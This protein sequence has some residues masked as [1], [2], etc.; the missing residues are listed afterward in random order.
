MVAFPYRV[1]ERK[2]EG[3][4]FRRQREALVALLAAEGIKN[5]Q[6]LAAIGTVPRHLFV[7]PSLRDRAYSNV[8][9]PIGYRQT[10]SQPYIVARMLE[11]LLEPTPPR[12]VLEVGVGSGYQTALLAHLVPEVY[13]VE[14]IRP[15]LERAKANLRPFRFSHVRLKWGD[16]AEG[17]PEAA[18]FDAVIAAAAGEEPPPAWF[19][20]LTTEGRIVAPVGPSDAQ[21]LTVWRRERGGWVAHPVEPVRF[22]PLLPG[23]E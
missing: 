23:K 21:W 20:Q 13:G 7:D 17:L 4:A 1:G 3:G 9:L 8:A 5:P 14:R 6:V 16:G 2:E 19:A 22:V 10:I 12:K 11:L 15:L 18:P